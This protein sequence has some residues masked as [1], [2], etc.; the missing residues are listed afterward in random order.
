MRFSRAP[1]RSVFLRTIVITTPFRLPRAYDTARPYSPRCR[2]RS[3]HPIL[4]KRH[5][6]CQSQYS[7]CPD[8]ASQLDSPVAPQVA[9]SATPLRQAHLDVR[10]GSCRHISH[11]PRRRR[12]GIAPRLRRVWMGEKGQLDEACEWRLHLAQLSWAFELLAPHPFF[13]MHVIAS[14]AVG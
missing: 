5:L 9:R 8:L 2:T 12:G 6:S 10:K 14:S 3:R 4:Q 7:L 11:L 13:A 1:C